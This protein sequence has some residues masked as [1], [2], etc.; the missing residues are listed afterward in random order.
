MGDQYALPVNT[1]NFVA[2]M[3]FDDRFSVGIKG[4]NLL[5]PYISVVQEDRQNIGQDLNV[6][7]FRRGIDFS[8]SLSYTF[9][10]KKKK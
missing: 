3:T 8:L 6:S 9:T 10:G 2:N 7:Q 4:R 5:N 1:L